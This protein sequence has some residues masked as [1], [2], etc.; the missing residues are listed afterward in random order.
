VMPMRG[1]VVPMLLIVI[2]PAQSST[3]TIRSKKRED[4]AEEEE[5][6]SINNSESFDVSL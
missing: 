6:L 1:F 3:S 2:E 4:L 5:A